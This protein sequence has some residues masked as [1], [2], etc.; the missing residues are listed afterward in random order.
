M[1]RGN[2]QR[3]P[4]FEGDHCGKLDQ[5]G[6]YVDLASTRATA[7]SCI[8]LLLAISERVYLGLPLKDRSVNSN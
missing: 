1:G 7:T 4:R 2:Q 8:C 5:E 3:R 6:G